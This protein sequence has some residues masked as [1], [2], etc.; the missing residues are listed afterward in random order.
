MPSGYFI[1]QYIR[2]TLPFDGLHGSTVRVDGSGNR[3]RS[4]RL[5]SPKPFIAD[6]SNDIPSR[7]ALSSSPDI[8]ATFF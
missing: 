4:E 7:K 1:S 3:R 5:A 2:M 6:A 8:T